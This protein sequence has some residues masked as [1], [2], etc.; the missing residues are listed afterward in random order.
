[1]GVRRLNGGLIAKEKG[2]RTLEFDSAVAWLRLWLTLIELEASGCSS[3]N[4]RQ[5]Q[6]AQLVGVRPHCQTC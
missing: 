3:L 4:T 1:M 6:R 5:P 2:G